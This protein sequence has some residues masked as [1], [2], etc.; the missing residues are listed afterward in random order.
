MTKQIG[1]LTGF[2]RVPAVASA[3]GFQGRK[4]IAM[5]RVLVILAGLVFLPT[6]C[7]AALGVVLVAGH[8][9]G[10]TVNAEQ[11]GNFGGLWKA[12]LR[13][14]LVEPWP[15]VRLITYLAGYIP[16]RLMGRAVPPLADRPNPCP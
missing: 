6:A 2:R 1:R 9:L 4:G 13:P 5:R 8:N 15:G 3:P 14:G 11:L 10:D 12:L 7:V 16:D